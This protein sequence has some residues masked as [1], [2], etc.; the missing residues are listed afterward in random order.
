MPHPPASKREEEKKSRYLITLNWAAQSLAQ[1]GSMA[2]C[3][4]LLACW[5]LLLL[6][7][8]CCSAT[9]PS[10]VHASAGTS[11]MASSHWSLPHQ[12]AQ[13]ERRAKGE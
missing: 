4:I 1:A 10:K 3:H 5:L 2:C 7:V 11:L 13:K 12:R 6:L 9:P 8:A